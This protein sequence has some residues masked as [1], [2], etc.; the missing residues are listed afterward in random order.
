MFEGRRPD[1]G[2]KTKSMPRV[3][4]CVSLLPARA[5]AGLFPAPADFF[6]IAC[7]NGKEWRT[8]R[9]RAGNH[10]FVGSLPLLFSPSGRPDA[11]RV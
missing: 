8:S 1:E 4:R 11:L 7:M 6:E 9:R 3:T 10:T 5:Y 2:M